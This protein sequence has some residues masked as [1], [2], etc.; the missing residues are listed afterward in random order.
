MS[1]DIACI[2]VSWFRSLISFKSLEMVITEKG[3][4]WFLSKAER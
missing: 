4:N 3:Y 2:V 1:C